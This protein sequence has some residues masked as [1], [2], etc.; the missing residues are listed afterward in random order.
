MSD[1]NGQ[2]TADDRLRDALDSASVEDFHAA[3]EAGANPDLNVNGWSILSRTAMA[4]YVE[5]L[6][7]LIAKGAKLN[8]PDING[9]TPVMFLAWMGQTPEQLEA[10]QRMISAG[11][12]LAIRDSEN[13]TALDLSKVLQNQPAT[14][15]L[16]RAHAPTGLV[17]PHRHDGWGR[18]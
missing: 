3:L 16:R 6:D 2:P 5:M 10:L 18:G 12:D 1:P 8:R 17:P 14:E 7:A 4:G 15:M 9:M 13:R 11:A